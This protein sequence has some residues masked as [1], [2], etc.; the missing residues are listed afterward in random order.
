MILGENFSLLAR[1]E[2][3]TKKNR[4]EGVLKADNSRKLAIRLAVASIIL[5]PIVGWVQGPFPAGKGRDSVVIVCS[6]CHPLTRISDSALNAEQWE[7][8]NRLGGYWQRLAGLVAVVATPPGGSL[9]RRVIH[10]GG[11]NFGLRGSG[12]NGRLR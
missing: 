2:P 8:T 3:R 5:C 9:R 11:W 1:S 10:A 7:L 12:T 4:Q 6:Q